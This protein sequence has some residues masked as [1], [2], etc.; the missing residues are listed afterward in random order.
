M[1]NIFHYCGGITEFHLRVHNVIAQLNS[2]R[3]S[4]QLHFRPQI[5]AGPG[6]PSRLR[7][8]PVTI[9][10]IQWQNKWPKAAAKCRP[11]K[12]IHTLA[13]MDTQREDIRPEF[14][15]C[16]LAHENPRAPC[17]RQL[18]SMDIK[19]HYAAT[20]K[21]SDRSRSWHWVGGY[22]GR[23]RNRSPGRMGRTTEGDNGPSKA[24]N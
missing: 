5:M 10:T 9:W 20:I 12:H 8:G 18:W 13:E 6:R 23:T 7:P 21:K 1:G 4:F 2:N 16:A 17:R 22:I 24:W 3:E 19:C 11:T 14:N 15:C